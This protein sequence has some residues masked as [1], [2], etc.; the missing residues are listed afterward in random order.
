MVLIIDNYDSFVFNLARYVNELGHEHLVF[1]NN[2]ISVEQIKV[3]NPSHIIISP[4]PCTP[5]EAGNSMSIVKCLGL[6]IPMLGVCLGHQVIYQAFCGKI[7]KAF[8]PLHGQGS[9]IR[10]NGQGI[11]FNIENPLFVGRYHSLI[12]DEE[13]LPDLEV[14]AISEEGEIMA[15]QHKKYPIYG[16]QFHPESILT[17]CGYDILNR[18]LLS[19]GTI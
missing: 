5:N 19:S 14:T 18:F 3:M 1:R 4:G 13:H 8:R 7:V 15:I 12:A 10:H 16:V 6:Y 11:F 17:A 9:W 2:K